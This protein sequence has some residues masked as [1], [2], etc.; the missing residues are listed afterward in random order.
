M[1]TF[2]NVFVLGPLLGLLTIQLL[3]RVHQI[4]NRVLPKSKNEL[5][6]LVNGVAVIFELIGMCAISMFLGAGI[7]ALSVPMLLIAQLIIAGED[8]GEDNVKAKM[9][10]ET[11]QRW[12]TRFKLVAQITFNHGRVLV[13]SYTS[14]RSPRSS[15]NATVGTTEKTPTRAEPISCP[16]K[17]LSEQELLQQLVAKVAQLQQ[18]A[19]R[20]ESDRVA[21]AE[22]TKQARDLEEAL[23]AEVQKLETGT[24]DWKDI[25][26]HIEGLNRHQLPA[27]L[28]SAL[29]E[30]VQE[31]AA[32]LDT[33]RDDVALLS[34]ELRATAD[35]LKQ[36]L[37]TRSLSPEEVISSANAALDSAEQVCSKSQS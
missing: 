12:S 2:I 25:C 29:N 23:N 32:K 11:Y 36:K 13:Q 4:K 27:E 1:G 10:I 5:R 30:L 37:T 31:R 15:E 14:S 7:L 3:A 26:S 17:P 16:R 9:V 6:V 18:W 21:V 19:S 20:P 34:S 22:L 33:N 35:N 28:S 8:A 24:T